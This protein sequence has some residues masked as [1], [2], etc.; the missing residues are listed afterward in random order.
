MEIALQMAYEKSQGLR[1]KKNTDIFTMTN[2][3][4]LHRDSQ[5]RGH[6][7][8][9]VVWL[10]TAITLEVVSHTEHLNHTCTQTQCQLMKIKLSRAM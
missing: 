3:Y 7:G 6:S 9:R 4:P 8:I 10:C 2:E 5:P 1:R